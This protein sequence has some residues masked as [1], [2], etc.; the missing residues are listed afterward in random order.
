MHE[1]D[2]SAFAA[3]LS[4]LRKELGLTQKELAEKLYISDK[5]ISKW[6][7]ALSMPDIS[8]LIPLA[9]ILGVTVTELLEG[10]RLEAEEMNTEQVE[11]IVKKALCFSEEEPLKNRKTIGKNIL[12]FGT[13]VIIAAAEFLF[14]W[15]L[16]DLAEIGSIFCVFEAL[17]L[18][19]GIYFWFFL[20]ERLPGYYDENRIGF[21]SDGFLKISFPGVAFNNTNWPKIGKALRLW[22]LISLVVI[23][24]VGILLTSLPMT[25]GLMFSL[26]MVCLL[27]YLGSL[28]LPI[29]LCARSKGTKMGKGKRKILITLLVLLCALSFLPVGSFSGGAQIG[30]VEK[31]SAQ[32]WYANY[33]YFDGWKKRDLRPKETV[34][35]VQ[36][37]TED[38]SIAITLADEDSLIF[39]QADIQT[40]TYPITLEG[41]TQVT[42]QAD[43]HKGSFSIAPAE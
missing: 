42:I 43:G 15:L 35:L 16:L 32:T 2:K 31:S 40:D 20:A 18:F 39:S 21:Y 1:I 8:L 17:S 27:L 9:E 37:V 26:Q 7:R 13:A 22:S 14:S 19:F 25:D 23:P 38:G 29:Y 36:V 5:A 24:L 4:Q 28:F 3:F 6:E 12:I 34:Y 10:R 30:Y 33:L 41:K 11:Q